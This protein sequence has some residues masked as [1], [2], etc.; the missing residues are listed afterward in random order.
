V[1]EP[2]I[3]SIKV[4][5]FVYLTFPPFSAYMVAMRWEDDEHR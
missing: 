3:F 2:E 4:K 1:T 5:V